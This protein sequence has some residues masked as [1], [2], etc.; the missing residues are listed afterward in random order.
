MS[1]RSLAPFILAVAVAA[2]GREPVEGLTPPDGSVV[3]GGDTGA[4]GSIDAVDPIGDGFVTD[5]GDTDAASSP[6]DGDVVIDLD[7]ATADVDP[8]SD[9][10][11]ST[12]ADAGPARDAQPGADALPGSDGGANACTTDQDCGF[13]GG[14]TVFCEPTTHTCVECYEDPQCRGPG[15]ICD[16]ANGNV[17]RSSCA[18][19]G[20][21]GGQ[22]CDPATDACVECLSATDCGAGEVCDLSNRSCV[23]CLTGADCATQV[24][25]P[26]CDTAAHQC[27]G[28][29]DDSSC[30]NGEICE[31]TTDTCVA[32][33]GRALCEPCTTDEQCGGAG[34]LCIG[35]ALGGLVDRACGIDCA[36]SPC[37][38]G[39]ECVP[40]RN[41]TAQQC[42]PSYEM[43]T[44]TC[45]AIRNLGAACPFS[46]DQLDPGCGIPN[47]QD[48]RCILDTASNAGVC[49]I[50]CTS[51]AQ[52]PQGFTCS[53]ANP[54]QSG[55]C[56]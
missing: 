50:F 35:A 28:C 47:V 23:G 48:A 55:F 9:T 11:T 44:P 19:G 22:V 51:D 45:T 41:G 10:G 30:Q 14:F 33:T 46:A 3:E 27:V 31:P 6:A 52:C 16:E 20:C 4:N 7:G 34:D 2:C 18:S 15:R 40:V 29:I 5:L 12:G 49:V 8:A 24:G 1:R 32:P 56:L 42:R 13:G 39:F 43:Q 17:C 37:P 26:I 38:R 21:R 36:S 53:A 54:N 25:R